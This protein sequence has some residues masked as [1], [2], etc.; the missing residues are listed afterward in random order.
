MQTART[1]TLAILLL[2]SVL[3]GC[4][5]A[6]APPAVAMPRLLITVDFDEDPQAVHADGRFD[7]NASLGRIHW[8]WGD[9]T[10]GNG[11]PGMSHTYVRNGTYNVTASANH[12]TA[13]RLT[14]WQEVVIGT[15]PLPESEEEAEA[16]E[17]EPTA[18]PPDGFIPHVVVGIA[19]S[20]FNVY[21]EVYRRPHLTMHPCTYI[22]DFPC[23]L[24]AL[25]LT[26][27][28]SSY[29]EAL[30]ADQAK[31]ESIQVGD[32]FWIPGTVFVFA[33]CVNSDGGSDVVTG[34]GDLCILDDIARHGTGTSSSVLSENPDALLAV[35]EGNSGSYD[36]L[37]EYAIPTDVRSFSWGAAAPLVGTGLLLEE[38]PELDYVF[39]AASGNEGAFPVVLDGTKASQHVITVGAADGASR[40]E[41]GYSGWKTMDFV[42]EYCRPTADVETLDGINPRYCGTSFS[43]P[44]FAGAVSRVI[45]ELRLKSGFDGTMEDG[46]VDPILGIDYWDLLDALRASASYTPDSPFE[47]DPH[48]VPL[49]ED[50]P[51]YQW[52]WGYIARNEVPAAV[53][54]LLDDVCAERPADTVAYMDALWT[55]RSV[56]GTPVI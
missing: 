47:N 32:A 16:P 5:D 15:V 25:D 35:V 18:P 30:A 22:R 2:G 37:D 33:G 7:D 44:T 50:A 6:D 10:S 31:W 19:D 51:Y 34:G 39:V 27:D 3:A 23:D 1:G 17:D 48:D 42:S 28:A 4:I 24:P 9:G 8:D 46:V 54:C 45:L 43:A 55:F 20:G 12:P 26:L 14:A 29:E 41:P 36:L 13:G 53:A 38:N 49:L 52:G 11:D 56:Y 40:T 21:H